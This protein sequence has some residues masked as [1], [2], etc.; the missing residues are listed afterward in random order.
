M[1]TNSICRIK[2]ASGV[3]KPFSS[4]C[5]VKL[6]DVLSPLLLN[7]FTDG[8]VNKL[9]YSLSESISISELSGNSLQNADDIVLLVNSEEAL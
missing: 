5:G 6:G 3:S 9:K 2:F 7:L 4:T 8:L 1:Y